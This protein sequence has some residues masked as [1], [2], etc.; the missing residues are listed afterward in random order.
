MTSNKRRLASGISGVAIAVALTMATPAWAQSSTSTLQ[1]T[2]PAGAEVVATQPSTG[3][4]RRTTVG[5]DGTYTIPGLPAGEYHVTAGGAVAQDVVLP[6]ASVQVVDFVAAPAATERGAIVVTSRRPTVETKT[7]Q[8]NQFV[9]LHDI[10]SLPQTTRNFLEFAD[11]VPG[12]QFSVDSSHNTTLRGGAQLNSAVNVF[13]D[14]VS[15]KDF[16]GTGDG[17]HGSGS[18]FVGSGGAEGNGDPGNP[19]PQLAISEYKVVSSNYTAEYGDAASAIIV[20]QTKSGT[21]DFQG[22]I[23]GTYT[24]EHLRASRPDEIASGKGKAHQPSKEYGVALGG[25]IVPDIA[26]VVFTWEHKSLANFSTVLPDGAVPDSIIAELPANVRDQFGPV[27]NPFTEN[28]YFGKIDVEPTQNDRIEVTGNL[29]LEH[30]VTG[31]NGQFAASTRVPYRNNVKRGD[32]RWQHTGNNWFN[33]FRVSYQDTESSVVA[34][35]EPSP[36]FDYFYF[37]NAGSNQNRVGIINVGGPGCCGASES[38]QKGWTFADDVTFTNVHLAGE[39]TLKFGASYGSIRLT[40]QNKT[41]DLNYATYSFA[42][43]PDG[44]ADTPFFMQFPNLKK[45]YASS[46]L[47]TDDKQYSAYVQ[48][49]WDV[50]PRL[51]INLGLRWDREEVPAFLD[52]VTNPEVVTALNSPYPDSALP[53][54]PAQN[55]ATAQ[56]G[57]PAID[58]NDYIS[59]GTNR[60]ARNNFSPR[61]GFSY[62]L[63]DNNSLVVFGG[64]ARAYNRNLFATLAL[65]TTKFALN[66]N[67]EIYFPSAQSFGWAGH[68]CQTAADVNPD[69]HCYAWDPA[70]LTPAGLA[71]FPAGATSGEVDMMNNNLR[72]PYSDQFS[73][74]VRTRLGEW[75]AQ[76]VAS[77]VASY[78]GIY[79]HWGARYPNGSYYD[80]GNQWSAKGVPGIGSLILWDNGFRDRNLQISLGAQ[81]PYTKASGWSATAAYTFSAAKQINSYDYGAGGNNYLFDYPSVDDYSFLRSSSVPR[82][83]LVLTGTYDL[84]WDMQVAGKLT[85]A[86]STPYYASYGCDAGRPGCAQNSNGAWVNSIGGGFGGWVAITPHDFLGYKDLDIQVTKNFNLF[87]RLS[88]YARVDVINVF[89]WHN[90]DAVIFENDAVGVPVSAHY[91]RIGSTVGSPFTIRLSAGARFGPAPPPPPVAEV[92]PPPP[93]PPASQTCPDGSVIDAAAACPAPPPPPPPAPPP[94]APV[95]RGER[96]Q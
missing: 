74:G 57:A 79:G 86:T 28:L 8:V 96:G 10:A 1:G 61:V 25:P 70:Y 51:Q 49:N 16:V 12:M 94:P 34:I 3:F 7:S 21:N 36:Q 19:F 40:K 93:P 68:P 65:E 30:N 38:R 66:D 90:Y 43:T 91:N 80:N 46:S 62:D 15:Q 35:D 81:K 39:H 56:P 29:R 2:A 45:G 4:V 33:A 71:T 83:R 85:L 67:P 48:D 32:A 27:T 26:H 53:N 18:G 63:S 88:A 9:T 75:N 55:L 23:F 37:P 17:T 5:P 95:E 42:V 64:Y 6:V 13:I 20:A 41:D 72:T 92:A 44:I 89:N 54:T 84:P 24:D 14:G 59:T 11:T 87:N 58:I 52:F 60:H 22:E 78:D 73:L 31:G 50:N 76:A 82:H 69:F 77:Y 47:T